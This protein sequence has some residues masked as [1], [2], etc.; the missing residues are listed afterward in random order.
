[1]EKTSDVELIMEM[2]EDKDNKLH[3]DI[4][5]NNQDFAYYEA[6]ATNILKQFT[7][8]DEDSFYFLKT[9]LKNYNKLSKERKE[10]IKKFLGLEKQVIYKEKIVYKEKVSKS[11]KAKPKLN[12][13]DDY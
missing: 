11:K 1:M 4:I 8:H 2:M 10:E 13:Y 7:N 9:I 12:T 6:K 5:D 3:D